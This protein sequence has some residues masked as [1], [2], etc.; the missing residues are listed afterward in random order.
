R[1]RRRR[2]RRREGKVKGKRKRQHVGVLFDIAA[3]HLGDGN[4]NLALLRGAG[5]APLRDPHRR[6]RLVLLP[7]H[8]HPRPRRHL[9][10][11]ISPI[12]L[13][14]KEDPSFKPSGGRL[15]ENDM[16]YDTDDKT[17]AALRRQLRK[18]REEYYRYKR[19]YIS[20]FRESRMGTLGSS[21]DIVGDSF[22]EL[23]WR[24]ILRK[25]LQKILAVTLGCM[26]VAILLAEA[27]LLPSGVDLSLF[28][29]LINAVGKQ[30]V[31]VQVKTGKYNKGLGLNRGAKLGKEVLE[32]KAASVLPKENSN[33][34][35]PKP[36]KQDKRKDTS[37][38]EAIVNKYAMIREQQVKKPASPALK[39]KATSS[40]SVSLLEAGNSQRQSDGSAVG[41]ASGL[42]STWA[43]M[44]NGFQ[45][46]KTNLGAKK[47]FPLRQVQ[48]TP[49]HSRGS[50]S[51]SL[52]EIFQKLK[53]RPSK[54]Q[55]GDFDFDD[56]DMG[57]TDM[58]S[59]R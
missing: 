27:T 28:S 39:E 13:F 3:A 45:S 56:N 14:L 43:S 59:T 30:E 4:D 36:P 48:E 47:F 38:H 29:I 58:R 18:A 23:L 26:S 1:N 19:K 15:G 49:L 11:T 57:I 44:K 17:M 33:G 50:S 35:P 52:D 16:D 31:L 40:A 42:T 46:F 10:R 32:V 24:C 21:L 12:C 54:N 55:D 6:I 41:T 51:E 25:Q 9:D 53:Q 2:R 37:S 8:Y 34:I 22:S 20:S 7:L 5:R